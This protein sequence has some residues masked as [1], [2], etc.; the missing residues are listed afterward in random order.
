MANQSTSFKV[1]FA[2]NKPPLANI[3]VYYRIGDSSTIDTFNKSIF[4]L[5]TNDGLISTNNP[6][7]YTD[8]EYQ[9][10]GLASFTS[11]QVKIVFRSTETSQVPKL[12]DL[13][14][15]VLA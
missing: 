6:T 13:R 12:K 1:I 9:L 8:A 11:I 10:S 4:T 15:I 7:N 5:V 14:L 2:Y 3:D